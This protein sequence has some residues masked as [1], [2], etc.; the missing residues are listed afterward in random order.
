MSFFSKG[1]ENST[2]CALP[3][4]I[5]PKIH[6]NH[7]IVFNISSGN[8]CAPQFGTVFCFFWHDLRE[9]RWGVCCPKQGF[10]CLLP[11]RRNR[12]M[13]LEFWWFLR[14][15]CRVAK[16]AKGGTEHSLLM[17]Q[18][19]TEDLCNLAGLIF[20][21]WLFTLPRFSE[22][23]KKPQYISLLSWSRCF[24]CII[25][26]GTLFVL[27]VWVWNNLSMGHLV[28]LFLFFMNIKCEKKK[29]TGTAPP[30]HLP[31]KG[32]T[33]SLVTIIL[34]CYV[35]LKPA[36]RCSGFWLFSF[37]TRFILCTSRHII[38]NGVN[39]TILWIITAITM[40]SNVK[41]PKVTF[42]KA[43]PSQRKS[44]HVFFFH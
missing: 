1:I 4:D 36:V 31:N 28:V 21:D 2:Y 10:M 42:W 6:P 15:L 5:V 27:C 35:L 19:T 18:C 7:T 32:L 11:R 38:W 13:V 29:K 3:Y 9:S 43:S 8:V 37:F 44:L 26:V 30:L 24:L 14:E 16:V 20:L 22:E 23:K 33:C 17:H 41:K 39:P 34:N 12:W 40:P 25:F